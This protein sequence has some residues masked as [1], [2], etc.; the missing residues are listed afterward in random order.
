[1]NPLS[2][3]SDAAA[4]LYLILAAGGS[5]GLAS[6]YFRRWHRRLPARWM[7]IAAANLL[8]SLALLFAGLLAGE[9]YCRHFADVTDSFGAHRMAQ[10]WLSRYGQLNAQGLRDDVIQYSLKPAMGRPRMIFIGD[11]FTAGSGVRNIRHRYVNLYRARHPEQDIQLFARNGWDTG[12]QTEKLRHLVEGGFEFR[13]AVLMYNLNDISDINPAWQ[14][15]MER[16]RRTFHP[17]GYFQ[18]SFLLNWFY[19]RMKMLT[20]MEVRNYGREVAA[21]YAGPVW[22]EQKERLRALRQ[23]VEDAGGRLVV[24][25]QP[26]FNYAAES[27]PFRAIHKQLAEFWDG[28]GV[29]HLDLLTL[30]D[31]HAPRDLIASRF[32]AH[33]N[34]TA[35][36][37]IA[38]RLDVFLSAP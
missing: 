17:T 14:R 23:T 13:T 36:R 38:E 5:G 7:R 12:H 29:P 24:A 1:M 4:L 20:D 8:L 19:F 31:G 15:M 18:H 11:S 3:S 22:E 28:E 37:L 25:T 32:D 30:L 2:P 21:A 35:H 9:I 34:E 6:V 16:I 27:Y 10:T 26:F 33:P